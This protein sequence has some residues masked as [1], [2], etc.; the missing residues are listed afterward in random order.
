MIAP[1][2][3][4]QRQWRPNI[5]IFGASGTGKTRTWLDLVRLTGARCLA[6]DTHHGTDAWANAY[7]TGWD[8]VHT[9]SPDEIEAQIDHY[10]ARPS[11]YSMFVVDDISVAHT[12]LQDSADDELRPMRKRKDPSV[13]RF[14]GVLDPGAWGVL[15]RMAHVSLHK[16]THL[17]MARVVV[18]RSKPHYQAGSNGKVASGS[19]FAGDKD[20][21]YSFDLVLQLEKFGATRVAIVEKARGIEMPATIED[22]TA[23]KLLALLPCGAAGFT[24]QAKPEALIDREQAQFLRALFADA[25]L[26]P[27][28]QTRALAAY[29]ATTIDDVPAARY[30]DLVQ[31]LRTVIAKKSTAVVYVHDQQVTATVPPPAVAAAT[32]DP[33][34]DAA[35]PSTTAV[36]AEQNEQN[37]PN[38]SNTNP[39][40]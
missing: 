30:L 19:T 33:A 24:D 10:C 17:D 1:Q 14:Q 35:A 8:V 31:A 7:P 12:M 28:R 22:F 20:M 27:G 25:A 15:K 40:N 16:L 4:Q 37:E 2:R 21:E 34:T 23:E 38:D 3:P 6:I 11:G 9:A 5:L 13:G 26:E 39:N 36:G 29:G 32:A 18:A